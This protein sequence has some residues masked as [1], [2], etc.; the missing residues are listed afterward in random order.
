MRHRIPVLIALAA[1]LA[2]G[3][4]AAP[5][6]RPPQP[7]QAA[8]LP[9]AR[10]VTLDGTPTDLGAAIH[11]RAALVT[12]WA[13][14]CDTCLGEIEGLKR[15]DAQTA[16]RSDALVV[17]VAVGEEP[18]TVA[19]FARAWHMAFLQLVD[20]DFLLVDALGQRRVPATL[21]VDRAGQIVYRGDALDA[22]GLAAF[23]NAQQAPGG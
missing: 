12:F 13:T 5:R 19:A 3:C 9:P 14:W 8:S 6:P 2:P 10:L 1:V 22:A 17:G 15:L 4:A 21:V 20:E 11:G 23:R 7:L 18:A 16:G